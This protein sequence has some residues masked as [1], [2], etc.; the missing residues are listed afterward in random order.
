[1]NLGKFFAVLIAGALFGF[2]LALSTMVQ[3]EVVLGFL[4]FEDFGLMLVLGGAVL[5]TLMAYQLLPRLF[6]TPLLG[7]HFH[8]HVSR[9]NRDTLQGA[10]L[11]GVGW[12]LCGVCPGPAIAGLGTGNWSLLWA[13]AGI[14]LG[15]L[16]QGWHAKADA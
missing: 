16:A 13:L 4:R 7:G 6:S 8:H 12:G 1:M 2:G 14:G 10:A 9:W 15:A 3:P 11:F 5:V